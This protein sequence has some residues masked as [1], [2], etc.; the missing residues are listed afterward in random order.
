MEILKITL[1][2]YE[3]ER[4]LK[5]KEKL[6][7]TE[8]A[9]IVKTLVVQFI[10]AYRKRVKYIQ[11]EPENEITP[12]YDDG[13][14][15][16]ETDNTKTDRQVGASS[17]IKK[18]EKIKHTGPSLQIKIRLTEKEVITLDEVVANSK[19]ARSENRFRSKYHIVKTLIES[20]ISIH[21]GA[22]VPEPQ[23]SILTIRKKW[24]KSEN[25]K[26]LS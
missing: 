21:E 14:N 5:I 23:K 17:P 19:K 18:S 9:T 26:K 12:T 11:S 8:N 3:A 2:P 13:Y 15:P 25:A 16:D 1:N 7:Y 6:N 10:R 22:I 4:F 20:H 24:R